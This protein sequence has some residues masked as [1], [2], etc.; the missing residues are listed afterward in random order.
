MK[1]KSKKIMLF[2]VGL[3]MIC[4]NM[5]GQIKLWVGQ[6][7][8]WDVASSMM[9]SITDL[10]W[11]SNGLVSLTG[12]GFYRN[13]TVNQYFEGEATVEVTWKYTLYYG[14]TQKTGRNTLRISC[15]DNPISIYPTSLR[16]APGQVEYLTYDLSYDNQYASA[17]QPYFSTSSNCISVTRDGKVT[18]LSAGTAYVNVYSKSSANSPYCT[19]IVEE[20]TPTRVSL[21]NDITLIEGEKHQLKPTLTPSNATTSYIWESEDESIA[22]VNSSGM[23]VAKKKG[24]TRIKVTTTKGGYSAYCKVVVKTPPPPPTNVKL[25]DEIVLYLGF[26]T[27]LTP[28]LEPSNAATTYNWKTSERSV[29]S[30]STTGK[31]TALS[32]GE[33][34]I[35]VTT[36]NGLTASCTIKVVE[37]PD[38]I[39]QTLL[40]KCISNLESLITTTLNSIK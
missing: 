3:F 9:G 40:Q 23:V 21:P 24:E 29:V 18:A 6:T 31:I 37:F 8:T 26:S 7:Y 22:E 5:Q 38:H 12:S 17:A 2:L 28:T 39:D 30:V 32:I 34:V 36:E 20:I 10:N 35:S 11:N 33:A 13:I 1:N 27:Q 19:V 15:Y 16:M 25:K 14:D 4:G